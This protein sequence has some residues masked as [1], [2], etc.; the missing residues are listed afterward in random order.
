LRAFH[1]DVAALRRYVVDEGLL[2]RRDG[3]SWRGGGTVA[4]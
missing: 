1:P 3:L 4:E 2:E